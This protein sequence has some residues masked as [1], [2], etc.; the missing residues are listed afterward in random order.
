MQYSDIPK[1]I[2]ASQ[3]ITQICNLLR[4]SSEH[5]K[6]FFRAK[7]Q[8]EIGGRSLGDIIV[9]ANGSVA[10]NATELDRKL[11]RRLGYRSREAMQINPTGSCD[12][13]RHKRSCAILESTY[14]CAH[15]GYRVKADVKPLQKRAFMCHRARYTYVAILRAS[16]NAFALLDGQAVF[17]YQVFQ[18]EI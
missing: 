7:P 18:L 8:H 5:L 16:I 4:L 15:Y 9:P 13:D 10:D 17:A 14:V 3:Q 2:F 12:A 6:T 1:Q 11:F